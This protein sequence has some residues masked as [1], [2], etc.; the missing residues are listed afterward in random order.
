MKVGIYF[1]KEDEK[2]N[3]IT[4]KTLVGMV[5]GA[6]IGYF[7]GPKIVMIEF[8]GE[9][10]LRT[11]QMAVVPL[12]FFSLAPTF[13]S[14]VTEMFP[15]N[16]IESAADGNIL[17]VIAFAIF[18]GIAILMLKEA[19]RKKISSMFETINKLIMKILNIVLEISSY[20]VF[21][22]MAVTAGK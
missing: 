1:G 7:V 22:L 8:V 9:I 13:S 11:L 3:L 15:R 5:L 20:G 17:Q 2:E 19:D 6:I 16:I 4:T 12:I 21:A 14:V 18:T 10:F